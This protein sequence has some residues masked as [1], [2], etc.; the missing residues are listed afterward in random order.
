MYLSRDFVHVAKT[1]GK[2]IISERFLPES[3]KTIQ[4]VSVGNFS[5]FYLENSLK[6][7]KVELL[8]DRNLLLII[9]YLNLQLM[10][11]IFSMEMIILRLR[12]QVRNTLY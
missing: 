5:T 6:F 1:Y 2:I 10:K 12:L 3:H 7:L 8:E 4:P 9:F 11:L